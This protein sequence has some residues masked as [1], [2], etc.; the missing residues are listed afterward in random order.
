[1]RV[2]NVN[3]SGGELSTGM[4]SS[5]SNFLAAALLTPIWPFSSTSDLM[6]SGWEQQVFVHMPGKVIFSSAR[7]WR[8]NA[9]SDGRNRNTE[10]ARWRSFLGPLISDI[11]WP[12]RGDERSRSALSEEAWL[13]LEGRV[14]R[15]VSSFGR[16]DELNELLS[17]SH[18]L[19]ELDTSSDSQTI[20]L[21][22][23]LPHA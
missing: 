6:L 23:H 22:N 9:P 15:G 18:Q 2:K 8:S 1:M 7:F 10:N 16:V 19:A 21:P 11:R 5:W 17:S 20:A 13:S 12:G 14:R 4:P 3:A